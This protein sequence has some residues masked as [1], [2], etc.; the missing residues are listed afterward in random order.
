M[1]KKT[2]LFYVYQDCSS[3]A[4]KEVESVMSKLGA[5]LDVQPLSLGQPMYTELVLTARDNDV[6]V[7][8]FTDGIRFSKSASDLT[9]RVKNVD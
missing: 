8:F 6:R 7:P 3:C 9:R 5:K 1:S 2:R 4:R